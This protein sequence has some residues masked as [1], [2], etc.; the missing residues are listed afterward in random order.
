MNTFH[1]LAFVIIFILHSKTKP[2]TWENKLLASPFG[3]CQSSLP[4]L[5]PYSFLNLVIFLNY[6]LILKGHSDPSSLEGRGVSSSR[7]FNCLKQKP[8][9]ETWGWGW[10]KM[11]MGCPERSSA[12][13]EGSPAALVKRVGRP[14]PWPDMPLGRL[15]RASGR[16]YIPFVPL[17]K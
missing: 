3:L 7:W 14:R 16:T 8:E 11:K 2:T 5:F 9:A 15:Q 12:L 17:Q 4:D 10:R 13:Q 1:L 6:P